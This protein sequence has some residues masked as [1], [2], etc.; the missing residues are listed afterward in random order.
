LWKVGDHVIHH[1]DLE[2]AAQID[3]LT[4][5]PDMTIT[6]TE[7]EAAGCMARVIEG[8]IVIG[9]TSE[10]IDAEKNQAQIDAYEAQLVQ[11]DQ[12][13]MAGR[14]IRELVLELAERAG[15]NGNAVEKL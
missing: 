6:V 10:E 7:F 12:D 2:A 1:T 4:R 13:A 15:I 11:I 5:Q 14:A 9:K 3:G 8:E